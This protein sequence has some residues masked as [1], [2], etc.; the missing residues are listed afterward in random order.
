MKFYNLIIPF[1]RIHKINQIG[2][3]KLSTEFTI[4]ETE[5]GY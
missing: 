1:V 5:L 3:L 2:G 4:P